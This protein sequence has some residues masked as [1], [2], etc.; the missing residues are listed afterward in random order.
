MKHSYSKCLVLFSLSL[1]LG[2]CSKDSEP[3]PS[4]TFEG[5]TGRD[6]NFNQTTP[7]DATDWTSDVTWNSSETG[8]FA[9]Y[10]L[11]FSLPQVARDTYFMSAFPSP[12]AVGGSTQ[13]R[14]LLSRNEFA[15]SASDLRIAYAIVDTNYTTLDYGF[16]DSG[17]YKQFGATITFKAVKYS[18]NTL[19]RLYYVIFN[20]QNMTVYYKGHGDIKVIL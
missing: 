1:A 10:N 7:Y 15:I 18:S 19:Y 16:A 12:V 20:N 6:A 13:L 4:T 17:V 2:A 5:Y 8:L 11:N 9:K 14:G 3:A